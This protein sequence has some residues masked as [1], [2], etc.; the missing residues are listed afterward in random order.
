MGARI[1][2]FFP[3]LQKMKKNFYQATRKAR[4]IF[5]CELY[6]SNLYQF[7]MFLFISGWTLLMVKVYEFLGLVAFISGIV[8]YIIAKRRTAR[9]EI[10]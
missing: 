1:N 3:N 2:Q 4:R 8:M 9:K 10:Y 5:N 7:S 6:S